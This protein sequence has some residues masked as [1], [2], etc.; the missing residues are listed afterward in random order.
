MGS[1]HYFL[2][3]LVVKIGMPEGEGIE[4][5]IEELKGSLLKLSLIA[6]FEMGD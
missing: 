4:Q 2:L 1:F 6:K 3:V 5:G